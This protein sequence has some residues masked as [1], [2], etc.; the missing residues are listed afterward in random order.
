MVVVM[1]DISSAIDTIDHDVLLDRMESTF[2]IIGDALSFFRSYLCNRKVTV[3]VR[4][5]QSS[6]ADLSFG[7][8]QGSALGPLLFNIYSQ[9]PLYRSR[10]EQYYLF[11]ITEFRYKGSYINGLEVLGERGFL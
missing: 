6:V 3:D 1:L 2:G 10:R 11:D 9:L 8:P 5:V 4:G 7:V